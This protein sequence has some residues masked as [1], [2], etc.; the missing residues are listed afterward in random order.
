MMRSRNLGKYRVT[1]VR[2]SITY[3][4]RLREN[5]CDDEGEKKRER[6]KINDRSL[7]VFTYLLLVS[8]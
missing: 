4:Y 8:L 3:Q 6:K 7:A 2:I 1:I 5:S